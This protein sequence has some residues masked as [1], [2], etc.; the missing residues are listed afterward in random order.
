[1]TKNLIALCALAVL[2]ACGGGG[3]P[4][5]DSLPNPNINQTGQPQPVVVVD[6]PSRAWANGNTGSAPTGVSSGGAVPTPAPATATAQTASGQPIP[7]RS[8][9]SL[10][11]WGTEPQVLFDSQNSCS[12]QPE[13]RIPDGDLAVWNA[14]CEPN[15]YFDQCYVPLSFEPQVRPADRR[16]PLPPLGAR[17]TQRPDPMTASDEE[18]ATWNRFC[19]TARCMVIAG[20]PSTGTP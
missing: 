7:P 5:Q 13:C 12:P 2:T 20:V 3:T 9:R 18:I 16:G 19:T 10:N 11:W 4:Y 8:G 14:Q 6:P 15:Q 17:P 1:M